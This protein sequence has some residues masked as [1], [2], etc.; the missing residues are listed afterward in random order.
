[1]NLFSFKVKLPSEVFPQNACP[2]FGYQK[3]LSFCLACLS[4]IFRPWC[5]IEM[6]HKSQRQKVN[7]LT[8]EEIF[9]SWRMSEIFSTFNIEQLVIFLSNYTRPSAMNVQHTIFCRFMRIENYSFLS[10]QNFPHTTWNVG[11][12]QRDFLIHKMKSSYIILILFL[13][14]FP[15]HMKLN[16]LE[17]GMKKCV[18]RDGHG[19]KKAFN[20][21]YEKSLFDGSWTRTALD[22]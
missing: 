8:P 9:L 11:G 15:F 22:V 3:F 10:P 4:Y 18:R 6:Y 14:P 13:S 19:T 5:G 17:S 1:M 16:S 20:F 21:P 7:L 12:C 2:F